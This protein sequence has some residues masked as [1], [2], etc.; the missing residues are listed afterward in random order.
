M[1]EQ[2]FDRLA[3]VGAILAKFIFYPLGGERDEALR[4]VRWCHE[5][6]IRV[7]I[8]TGGVSRSGVSQICGYDVLAW[9]Q[10]DIAAHSAA[11][12]SR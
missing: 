7:K 2:H 6:G 1:T 11:A 3:A 5:R 12:R 10:P 4:Y 8:H 9:L